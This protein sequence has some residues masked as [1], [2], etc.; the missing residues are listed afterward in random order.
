MDPAD[1]DYS[2]ADADPRYVDQNV[3]PAGP[4]LILAALWKVTGDKSYIYMQVLQIVLDSLMVVLIWWI[5]MRLFRDRRAALVAAALYALFLPIASFMRLPYYDPWAIFLTIAAFAQLLR[6]LDSP[7]IR[8]LAGLGAIIGVGL[9]FHPTMALLPIAFALAL[10]P[11][12]GWRFAARVAVVPLVVTA[13]FGAPWTIKN[14]VEHEKFI[15][16]R[17]TAGQVLWQ[18]LG[19]LD[20]DFGAER[21]DN[22]T[23]RMV[24]RERPELRYG[25]IEYDEFLRERAVEEIKEHPGFWAKLVAFRLADSTFLM[26]S[27][28]WAGK[29]RTR[30]D[31]RDGSIPSFVVS[32]PLDAAIV[33]LSLLLEPF[34]FLLAMATVLLTWRRLR[35]EH[36]LLL[37]VPVGT[38]AAPIL[39]DSDWRYLVPAS[40]AYMILAGLGVSLLVDRVRA[41]NA[42]EPGVE[43][44]ASRLAAEPER[45]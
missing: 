26:Q 2:D 41:S 33:G 9:Y 11:A 44:P 17:S 20:N 38:M 1:V 8:R 25:T 29:S 15:A 31:E 21:D 16:T 4:V 32:R 13:A 35:Q 39:L 5:S 34:V 36:L 12:R 23:E 22:A 37:A 6:V 43:D 40:F 45:A 19:Q 28:E 24:R 14:Y 10:L 27:S 42:A 3:V 30:F 7:S 18:G